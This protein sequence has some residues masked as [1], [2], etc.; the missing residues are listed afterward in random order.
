MKHFGPA[1]VVAAVVLAASGP[2]AA[3]SQIVNI[4][5]Y[6]ETGLTQPLLDRFE[7]ETGIKPVLLFG[8]DG[9]IERA[10]AEGE[11]SPVDLILTVDI[12]NL[13]AAKELGV[14]QPIDPA[15]LAPVPPAYRDPDGHWTALSMRARVFYASRE[16]VSEQSLDYDDIAGPEWRGRLCT[17]SGQ[18]VYNI[19]L[20]ASRIVHLGLD[21]T[22]QWLTAVRD[23]LARKPTGNDRA[24]VQAVYSGQCDLAIGNTYY[25]GLML[26]N[27]AEPQQKQWAQSV[28]II[29]PD[30]GGDG[31]HVNVSGVILARY[32]P[33]KANAEKLISFLLSEEAQYLYAETNHEFPILDGVAPS[34]LVASWG[35]LDADPTPLTEVAAQRAA[36]SVL[37]DE[38]RFDEGPRN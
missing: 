12:G 35:E 9:L 31:T 11:N 22:R 28:R 18:H 20:I 8:G 1:A 37:V 38:L 7:A 27:E 17:R 19:G 13:V 2:A 34:A 21:G 24:Q 4:Y 15:I 36:A 33:H 30:A 6:R 26:T 16:R 32:A 10:A 3:Q 14:S 29:Y 5:S 23:N 25:M